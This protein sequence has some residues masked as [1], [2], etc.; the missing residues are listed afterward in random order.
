MSL[1]QNPLKDG[2]AKIKEGAL[3]NSNSGKVK[4]T[5]EISRRKN[6]LGRLQ[7]KFSH[8]HFDKV[9]FKMFGLLYLGL[10]CSFVESIV[11]M[12]TLCF[13]MPRS[14]STRVQKRIAVHMCDV[15]VAHEA[16]VVEAETGEK[17]VVEAEKSRD[18]MMELFMQKLKDKTVY[19]TFGNP[20]TEKN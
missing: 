11:G 14:L 12:I 8:M 17:P 5:V 4:V 2:T 9:H 6:F 16:Y 20:I 1:E 19:D 3:D 13:W 15:N 18:E 10:V 7:N